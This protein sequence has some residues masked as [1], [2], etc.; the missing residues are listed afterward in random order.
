MKCYVSLC[1]DLKKNVVIHYFNF[2]A[3]NTEYTLVIISIIAETIFTASLQINCSRQN[4]IIWV[5]T[6]LMEMICQS[7]IEIYLFYLVGSFWIHFFQAPKYLLNA[8]VHKITY[9]QLCVRALIWPWQ[10]FLSRSISQF[11][12]NITKLYPQ[13]H[14]FLQNK[15]DTRSYHIT[16]K[17]GH[18]IHLSE[19][20]AHYNFESNVHSWTAECLK[21]HSWSVLPIKH[22]NVSWGI[23][24]LDFSVTSLWSNYHKIWYTRDHTDKNNQTLGRIRSR[25][26]E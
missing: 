12:P 4:W 2:H 11:S 9:F 13:P 7:K 24:T 25:R 22:S 26:Q 21:S 3:K 1:L 23:W 8:W 6:S 19:M 20:K 17:L 10:S 16:I 18:L 5:K 14:S 15:T